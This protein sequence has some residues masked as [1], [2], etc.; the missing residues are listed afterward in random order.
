[1]TMDIHMLFARINRLPCHVI[2]IIYAYLAIPA[3]IPDVADWQIE[4]AKEETLETDEYDQDYNWYEDETFYDDDFKLIGGYFERY[5]Q[6][7][8]EEEDYGY[9]RY[10][11]HY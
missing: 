1:M 11:P 4:Q 2:D 3:D 10:D 9:D 6:D 8:I 5:P 7:S